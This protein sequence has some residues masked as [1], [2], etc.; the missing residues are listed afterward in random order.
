[1]KWA[2]HKLN[3]SLFIKISFIFFHSSLF[4]YSSSLLYTFPFL[5]SS[6]QT[7]KFYSHFIWIL[8]VLRKT[9]YTGWAWNWILFILNFFTFRLK[10]VWKVMKTLF[11][12]SSKNFIWFWKKIHNKNLKSS[13]RCMKWCKMSNQNIKKWLKY[14]IQLT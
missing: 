14:V 9:Y 3:F 2:T 10:K 11:F 12:I 7:E 6:S 1:M 4:L 13:S 8:N 5:F